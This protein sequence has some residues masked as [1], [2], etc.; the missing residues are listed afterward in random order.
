MKFNCIHS[1]PV[2][3]SGL[4]LRNSCIDHGILRSFR[5]LSGRA[6]RRH[7]RISEETVVARP[8]YSRPTR[9]SSCQR[10]ESILVVE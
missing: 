9:R 5:P 10:S 4:F 7:N 8:A 1:P 2:P 6:A 3:S